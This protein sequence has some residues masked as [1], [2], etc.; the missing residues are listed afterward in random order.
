[1]IF[2]IRFDICFDICFDIRFDIHFDIRF[3]VEYFNLK[4]SF[5]CFAFYSTSTS[6]LWYLLWRRIL[7]RDPASLE[8]VGNK[9]LD[10]L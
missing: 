7:K 9:K 2:A 10:S 8:F 4:P 5:F 1:M 3:E 6:E